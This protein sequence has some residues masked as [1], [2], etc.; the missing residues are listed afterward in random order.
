[1]RCQ[2]QT[3]ARS[4]AAAVTNDR[5]RKSSSSSSACGIGL[6]SVNDGRREESARE[7]V[8]RKRE[9]FLAQM[10]VDVREEEIAK[11]EK[12]AQQ[13][14]EALR[15]AERMLEEDKE[16]FDQFLKEN[17]ER[18]REATRRAEREAK[19]KREKASE[20]KRLN[21]EIASARLDLGRREDA[22][23]ECEEY[24]MFLDELTP[25][26][27]LAEHR[28]V[29]DDK[30][31]ALTMIDE[32][33]G[34]DND[35]GDHAEK[36]KENDDDKEEEEEAQRS[37]PV[38]M[39]FTHPQQ[40]LDVFAKLE[41]E[42]LSL[43]SEAQDIE[44]RLERESEKWAKE[45]RE[46]DLE[47]RKNQIEITTLREAIVEENKKKN[48]YVLA[49][50]NINAVRSTTSR[51]TTTCDNVNA[52]VV[53]APERELIDLTEKVKEVYDNVVV[54]VVLDDMAH[55]NSNNN[56]QQENDKSAVEMLREIED[57]LERYF[58]EV[59]KMPTEIVAERERKIEKERRHRNREL[60]MQRQKAE[61]EARL[62]KAMQRASAP[63]REKK[64]GKPIMF[65]SR[66]RAEKDD[67]NKIKSAVQDLAKRKQR[68]EDIELRAFMNR[69]F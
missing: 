69:E 24:L 18:V 27:W 23:E 58:V 43:I 66:L 5:D 2:S 34:N 13:R 53:V 57:A 41:E 26:E 30:E 35:D 59:E 52:V 33:D 6:I 29:K 8:Q 39:Y 19:K 4:R 14:E 3:V 45:L 28:E 15:N 31:L 68:Q 22:L 54:A 50:K 55:N 42:N 60:K 9:L 38:P 48:S 16:R 11:L 56:N 37:K 44:D 67:S 65:R 12:R 47:S 20:V 40:L 21:V 63:A 36:D 10:A 17:D 7:I 61:Q 1:M 49:D 64:V 32:D 25:K 62:E 51:S 46:L